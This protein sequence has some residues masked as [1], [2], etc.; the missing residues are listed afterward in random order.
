MFV[1]VSHLFWD[2][3]NIARQ[4]NVPQMVTMSYSH[5]VEFARWSLQYKGIKF[6]ES[7][8][9]P[10]QHIL[11]VI[12]IRVDKKGGKYF[13]TS[14]SISDK[15]GEAKISP[16][17]VPVMINPDG[18]VDRD[19]WEISSR[20]N[21]KEIE[22]D[23][24]DILDKQLGPLTRQ[25]AY[26]YMLKPDNLALFSELCTKGRHW[27]WR[28]FW[29]IGF[30]RYLVSHMVN[31]FDSHN[32]EAK[33]ECIEKIEVLLEKLGG[34]VKTRDG[35]FLAGNQL[36]QADIA[37]ASICGALMFPD[38][39]GEGVMVGYVAELSGRDPEFARG[40][41]K[42]RKTEVGV[43]CTELYSKYRLA[44]SAAP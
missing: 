22:P 31:L 16:T 5:Y 1:F 25:W 13:S 42:W 29:F 26:F 19:S 44:T 38:L 4:S 39:Y 18:S 24:K 11:P 7:G 15:A 32:E 23:L 17:S 43:Y 12:S 20:A 14:S 36:G 21:L 10:G 41:E 2:F 34:M 6:M 30:G 9:A 37:L 8:Y 28:L 35:K 33:R 40:V 27:F 3:H